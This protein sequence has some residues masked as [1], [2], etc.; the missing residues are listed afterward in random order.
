[1][2]TVSAG[3]WLLFDVDFPYPA[4]LRLKERGVQS[5]HAGEEGLATCD[6]RQLLEYAREDGCL[7]VTRNYV[8][9]ARLAEAYLREGRDFPAVLFVSSEIK[10]TDVDGHV[11]AI[12]RWLRGA[13]EAGSTSSLK[14]RYVWL[15]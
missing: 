15:T 1:M 8:G 6:D 3:I 7:I 10:E 13:A 4:Y 12:E 11:E 14:N 5:I 9:F 2:T